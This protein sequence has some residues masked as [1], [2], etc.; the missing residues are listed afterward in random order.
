MNR[1]NLL[2]SGVWLAGAAL[3]PTAV[4]ARQKTVSSQPGAFP[5][6]FLW[7]AATAAY[8]VEGGYNEDG[9]GESIWDR[10]V[11]APG[12]IK[13]GNTGN[14]ACD[15][16]HKWQQDIALLKAMNLTSYRFS[17]AWTRIQ[18]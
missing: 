5:A 9:K 3:L 15:S 8:Q 7:G 14:V 10:F 2:R 1:R 12:K 18:P 13:N 17:T 4:T 11:L 16:Y 6:G